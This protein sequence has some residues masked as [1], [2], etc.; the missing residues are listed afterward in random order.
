MTEWIDLGIAF[1]AGIATGASGKYLAD[2][3]TDQRRRGEREADTVKRF[4]AIVAQMPKL[5]AEM[6]TDFQGPDGNVI[7]DIAL[8]HSKGVIFNSSGPKFVYY[9]DQYEN[10][11]GQFVLLENHGFAHDITP[12]NVPIY[13]V[14][15]E[16]VRLL[17]AH[18]R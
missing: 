11:V 6:A 14:S 4:K 16:F 18:R 5:I 2:R 10:L 12:G 8:L 15:E 9:Q 3:F 1:L 7:R 17:K 13:R